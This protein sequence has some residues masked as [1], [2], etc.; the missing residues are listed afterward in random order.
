LRAS[1][2]A[3]QG[4][5]CCYCLSRITADKMKIEHWHSQ[6]RPPLEKQLD[7][8]NLLGACVGNEGRAWKEQHCDTRKG[9]RTLS[10]NPANPDHRVN[11]LLHF[12]G[13][14]RIIS[15]DPDFDAELNEVLNL[16]YPR[17][18]ENRKATLDGFLGGLPKSGELQRAKLEK[19]LQEWNG[20]SQDGQ[21]RPFCQVVVYWLCKRLARL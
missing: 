4:G 19:L 3:E 20:V 14:G 8:S 7:Y 10:R 1:L 17:L 6:S 12:P 9:D 13:D 5:L 21:L 11:D 15:H 18:K 16:N 2:L